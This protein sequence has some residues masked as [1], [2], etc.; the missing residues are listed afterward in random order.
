MEDFTFIEDVALYQPTEEEERHYWNGPGY[1]KLYVIQNDEDVFEFDVLDYD[2]CAGGAD[3]TVGFDY[4]ITDMLG[5]QKDLKEGITYTIQNLTVRWYRGDGWTTDDD[6]D[7]DFD[8]II[9][10]FNPITWT[11]QK[12]YNFWWRTIGWRLK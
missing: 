6:V 10:H 4:L 7:Y 2:G 1:I 5:L 8:E 11:R 3:E 9:I 12:L